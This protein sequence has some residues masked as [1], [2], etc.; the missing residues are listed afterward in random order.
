MSRVHLLLPTQTL[1]H[2][3]LKFP[4]L[5]AHSHFNL[6]LVRTSTKGSISP[7]PK[8]EKLPPVNET[9]DVEAIAA[10]Y[11]EEREK[12]L[13]VD[14]TYQYQSVDEGFLN[15]FSKDTWSEP[16]NRGLVEE[17]V[18]FFIVGAGYSGMIPAVRLLQ[19]GITNIKIIDKSGDFGET[20]Y[21][22]R[23]PGAACDIEAYIYM[24]LLEETEYVP[25]E[26]YAR[27][28][29]LFEHSRRI[30]R[31][32]GLYEKTLF[33]TEV[34]KL[35]RNDSAEKWD[36]GTSRGDKISA[37]FVT[38]ATGLLHKM[39]FPGVPGIE[40]FKGHSFHTSRWGFD[41]TGGDVSGNLHKMTDKRVGIIGTG[42]TAIQVVP[43]LGEHSKHLYAFQRTPS[44]IDVR[45]DQPT[46]L[47]GQSL[48]RKALSRT[49]CTT[50]TIW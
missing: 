22:N 17:T 35:D 38:T 41:Y 25:T 23:Y 18:D 39:K 31:T 36:I 7:S 44:S 40:K 21:W 30:G 4:V 27:G 34:T 5:G 42:A 16:I 37:Q 50:L 43:H 20:W 29:E 8:F 26:K 2:K 33:Q 48:S 9:V 24:P 13:P 10:R 46:D 1:P 28:P 45:L 12:S 6:F 19:A 49:E 47:N 3:Q 32:F 14:G 15:H 11:K